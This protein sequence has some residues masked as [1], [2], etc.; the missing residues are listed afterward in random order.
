MAIG[1]YEANPEFWND[2]D[3][4]FSFGLF[5]LD[6][7]TFASNMDGHL[8][9]CPAIESAGI[10]S[11]VC[12][13]ES[14]TPDHKALLGPQYGLKGFFNA[15][16]FNSMGMLLGGGCGQ[17][18][19]YWITE[20][21]PRLDM[22][23]MDCNRFHKD[24]IQDNSWVHSRTHESYAKTY[25]IVYPFDESLSGRNIRTSALHNQLVQRGCVHQ[26]RHGFERPGWFV[27]ETGEQA[28]KPY[29]FY[30]AYAEDNSAWRVNKDGGTALAGSPLLEV[31]QIPMHEHN[32]YSEIIQGELTFGWPASFDLVA[33]ECQAARSGP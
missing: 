6:W 3:P 14:F 20:G 8:Q 33:K 13:P 16:G 27:P 2:V 4:G 22:F 24:A 25:A 31:D 1:G 26:A 10:K 5:D 11:T 15:C 23:S 28:P 19:A 18:L 7:D 21:S 17:E 12:G 32:K 30:G 9:R 29:D